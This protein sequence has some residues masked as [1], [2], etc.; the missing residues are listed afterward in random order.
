MKNKTKVLILI[1]IILVTAITIQ[2]FRIINT[3]SLFKVKQPKV[4]TTFNY[5]SSKN[6]IIDYDKIY[7]LYDKNNTNVNSVFYNLIKVL[8]QAKIE[9]IDIDL[10]ESLPKIQ[11]NDLLLITTEQINISKKQFEELTNIG[12]N[13]G[14][15]IRTNRRNI[16]NFIGVKEKTYKYNV[17]NGIK[18]TKNIFPK[19]SDISLDSDVILHSLLNITKDDF[20]SNVDIIAKTAQDNPIIWINKYNKSKIL[21]VNSTLFQ[22]KLNRG[23]MLQLITYINNN[24]LPVIFN[25]KLIHIDDFPAPIKQGKDEIIFKEYGIDNSV[26][27]KN[28]WLSDVFNLFKKYDFKPTAFIIG[29]YN[30]NVNNPSD[31]YESDINDI[32]YLGRKLLEFDSELGIHGYNHNSLVTDGE[33][34]FEDYGYNP[35]PSR[36][37]M[38]DPSDFYESDIN[39]INYLGRKLLEFDSE[40][41]IHGYNHN[42]LVTDGEMN[43]EDYGYNPWP[44]RE[45]MEEALKKLK[46][47]IYSIYGEIPIYSYVPPSNIM[48]IEGQKAVKNVFPEIKVYAGLYI[49][50]KEKGV[51][52]QEFGPNEVV[53]DVYNLPRI[54]SGY[55]YDNSQLWNIY[56]VIAQL[57][58]FNHFIHPDDLLSKERSKNMTWRD[59]YKNFALLLKDVHKSFPFLRP[60]TTVEFYNSYK[61]NEQ[62]KVYSK[63][64]NNKIYLTYQTASFP[65]NHYFKNLKK[66]KSITGGNYKLLFSNNEYNLYLIT[67][68][69]TDVIIELEN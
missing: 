27:F 20:A 46:N 9:H 23:L 53:N 64:E 68:N 38:E 49:A 28:I 52:L 10:N 69:S 25:A 65:I 2:L 15:L 54:S 45:K 18:F 14:F 56:N 59:L 21:F 55:I 30:L 13:I 61:A 51:F 11:K 26:F 31:F 33:M 66:I 16:Q 24:F 37:K 8:E 12:V 40:L 5:S 35:W 48:G 41:G 44:S 6:K 1:L 4:Q 36:E 3:N 29:Q 47:L 17:K 62:L 58:Y 43:F 7:I 63:Q 22:D 42:S 34:N 60:M 67:S 19:L 57:G 39:D 32:N 50:S